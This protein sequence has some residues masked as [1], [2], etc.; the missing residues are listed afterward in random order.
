MK[1]LF[2]FLVVFNLFCGALLAQQSQEKYTNELKYLLYLPENYNKDDQQKFPVVLFLHGSGERGDDVSKVAVNG[3]PKLIADGK[4]FP[5]IVVSPQVPEGERW[6]STDL[7]RLMKDIKKK[8]RIDEDRLYL[9]G[10]SM[11]GYGSWDMAMKYPQMFAAV[12]PICGGGDVSKVWAIRHTPVWVFH[13]G[14][15][16]V[17]PLK[18]SQDMVNA[19]KPINPDVKFTIFPED[20]HDSWTSAYNTDSLYTWLLGIKKFKYAKVPVDQELLDTY[21]GSYYNDLANDTLKI[22]VTTGIV[23][24]IRKKGVTELKPYANEKFFVN[25]NDPVDAVF[26]GKKRKMQLLINADRQYVYKR[27]G[28]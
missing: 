13:G 18:A 12:V 6:E 22:T 23:T 28:D 26:S 16:N 4:K 17:V 19:L 5:F 11:G 10:L 14:K 3:L 1:F 24:M 8:Y 25:E 20:G 9:T 21:Q 27:I 15:D 7:M 2:V